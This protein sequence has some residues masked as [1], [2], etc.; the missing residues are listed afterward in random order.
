VC[1]NCE[2]LAGAQVSEQGFD[3]SL[4]S[5]EDGQI[6]GELRMIGLSLSLI[7]VAFREIKT[8]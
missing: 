4:F 5:L 7:V 6:I 1:E 3:R 8:S 2:S